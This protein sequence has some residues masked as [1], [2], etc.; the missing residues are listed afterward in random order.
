MLTNLKFI[1]SGGHF[2]VVLDALLLGSTTY[3][4]SL[5]DS[6]E[7][8]AGE[9][10]CGLIVDS[11]PKSLLEFEGM[12]HVAI[13]NNEARERIYQ[14]LNGISALTI[15]H[16]QAVIAH[17][18]Q[19]GNGSFIAALAILGPHCSVGEGSIINHGAIVDHDVHIG[20][21]SHV[22][23]NSTLGGNVHLGKGVLVGAGAVV[24]PGL[25]LGEGSIIAAGAVVV[26][27]VKPYTTVKG[28]PAV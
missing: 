8:R 1:G 7:E 16:P 28:V 27:D 10:V 9:E 11:N 24:L 22:A 6:N 20:A 18:S 21:Y 25:K 4:I 12:I 26:K 14:S 5:F 15:K 19:I 23:P 17:S 2:K 13:G 3:Q